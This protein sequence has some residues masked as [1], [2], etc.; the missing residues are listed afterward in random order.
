MSI[1]SIQ[2]SCYFKLHKGF[3]ILT[4]KLTF[5]LKMVILKFAVAW[6]I[7]VYQTHFILYQ[8]RTVLHRCSRHRRQRQLQTL[9]WPGTVVPTVGYKCIHVAQLRLRLCH[10]GC[11]T[12]L[13]VEGGGLLLPKESCLF[14]S[15]SLIFGFIFFLKKGHDFILILSYIFYNMYT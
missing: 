7:R 13:A 11:G 4:L 15:S 5:I 14:K 6:D 12:R 9:R 8:I 3:D 10:G 2:T 1:L